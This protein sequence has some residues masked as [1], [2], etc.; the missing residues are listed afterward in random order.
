MRSRG[1]S[2]YAGGSSPDHQAEPEVSTELAPPRAPAAWNLR[3]SQSAAGRLGSGARARY[4]QTPD[5][6]PI[7][8]GIERRMTGW[9]F[10]S[11]V[12]AAG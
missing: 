4:G 10:R 1:R 7:F 12:G 8:T 5:A 3:R 6:D 11:G 9:A 2:S